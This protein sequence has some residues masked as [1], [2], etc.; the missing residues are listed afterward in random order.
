MGAA[1][2]PKLTCRVAILRAEPASANG[3]GNASGIEKALKVPF[4]SVMV[5]Q[6]VHVDAEWPTDWKAELVCGRSSEE[7]RAVFV[8]HALTALREAMVG[9]PN[10]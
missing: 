9:R 3:N 7:R 2:A 5:P 10:R 6:A 8:T 4:T 1:A